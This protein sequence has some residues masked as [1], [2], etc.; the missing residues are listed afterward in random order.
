ML[1]YSHVLLVITLLL[2]TSVFT[3]V[4]GF[5]SNDSYLQVDSL[6]TIDTISLS[7]HLL[8]VREIAHFN[9]VI[10]D[11]T[12]VVGNKLE[13]K[14]ITIEQTTISPLDTIY[15]KTANTSNP[16]K[17]FLIEV[18]TVK[19]DEPSSMTVFT[20][21]TAIE[22]LIETNS[23]DFSSASKSS[24]SSAYYLNESEEEI[25]VA[26]STGE[27][28]VENTSNILSVA[29]HPP[30]STKKEGEHGSAPA[31]LAGLPGAK[32]LERKSITA[33]EAYTLTLKDIE[34]QRKS[35]ASDFQKAKEETKQQQI[36]QAAAVYFEESI[37][38]DVVHYWYGTSFD[39]EGM[40][41]NPNEGKI[42]CSYFITT[43]LEDAGLRVNRVK[44]AQQSAQNI[45]QTLCNRSKMNRL[46]TPG[47]VKD[48][49]QKNGKGLYVIG[50]SFHVGFLYNDGFDT[51]LIHASPLPPG[52]VARLPMEGA[53]SFDY[54]K[55]YDIGK[56][57]DNTDLIVKWLKGE[58]VY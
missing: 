52:T 7:E 40:A 29:L 19:E 6:I 20:P 14:K 53:R 42:A 8:L 28:I 48:Y 55:F 34:R 11:D 49:V 32:V 16:S 38:V 23:I 56:L 13:I 9:E 57:S 58:K 45:A 31:S 41:R 50:F 26:E 1:K 22:Q 4:E 18:E 54:S 24:Y 15:L 3:K 27:P 30:T 39:K 33:K 44:L 47:E 46:T 37:A 12:V 5:V 51:Y 21:E 25:V 10:L 17:E 35:F 2:T 36:L 43:V